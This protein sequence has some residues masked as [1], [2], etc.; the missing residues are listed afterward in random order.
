MKTSRLS[1]MLGLAAAGVLSLATL[2][3]SPAQT[4]RADTLNDFAIVV[5]L[6][7]LNTFVDSANDPITIDSDTTTGTERTITGTE[8]SGVPVV[9]HV[10]LN[11]PTSG[12]STSAELLANVAAAAGADDPTDP[13]TP[14]TTAPDVSTFVP[15]VVTATTPTTITVVWRAPSLSTAFGLTIDGAV[16]PTQAT[17]NFTITGLQ[18]DTAHDLDLE[19][20]HAGPT[21][22]TTA[23]PTPPVSALCPSP[24]GVATTDL[25][26]WNLSE[27][28]SMGL[29]YIV[30]GG[31]E[32]L[33]GDASANGKA[34]GYYPSTFDLS[35]AGDPA[36][37]WTGSTTRPGLQLVTDFNNDGTPDGILV[38]ETAYGSDWWASNG[39]AQFV[40]DNAPQHG[41]GS[42]SVNH[43]TLP[44]W[45]TAFPDAKVLAVGY[46]LGSGAKGNGRINSIVAGCTEYTFQSA[47]L[48]AAPTTV[49]DASSY[50]SIHTPEPLLSGQSERAHAK[51]MKQV[52]TE[53]TDVSDVRSTEF[54]YRT[55]IPYYTTDD[56]PFP[57]DQLFAKACELYN[58][59]NP[60]GPY[61][62][63]G[64]NRSF[65]QPDADPSVHDYRTM[66]DWKVDWDH[67]DSSH[68]KQVGE[69]KLLDTS[70]GEVLKSGHADTARM[71]FDSPVQ[72]SDFAAV[73]FNH[74]AHD[75]LCPSL[76]TAGTVAYD[77]DV[78]FYRSGMVTV[79]GQRFT[80]PAHEGW[81]RW[82]GEA[83]W[84][85]VFEAKTAS[86]ACL[87]G[88]ALPVLFNPCVENIASRVNRTTDSW[89]SFDG[90]WGTTAAGKI[91]GTGNTSRL[92]PHGD[93]SSTCYASGIVRAP[94][95]PNGARVTRL[96]IT[97]LAL[98]NRT[99]QWAT[100]LGSDG[101]IYTWG[102][103]QA[104]EL[105]RTPSASDEIIPT[106]VDSRTYVDFSVNGQNTFAVT[107]DG[108]VYTW[109]SQFPDPHTS[110]SPAPI[111]TPTLSLA[112]ENIQHV[113][114]G[115][116]DAVALNA[117]GH[118]YQFGQSAPSDD[119]P[120]GYQPWHSVP[121]AGKTFSDIA[122][123]GGEIDDDYALDTGG[124]LWA[125]NG[126]T[127]VTAATGSYSG[128]RPTAPSLV[129]TDNTFEVLTGGN[130]VVVQTSDGN[131]G[132]WNEF[133]GPGL[134]IDNY[135]Y[136][137]E[138]P[139]VTLHA[140]T[141]NT[142]T[143]VSRGIGIDGS[144][145]AWAMELKPDYSGYVWVNLGPPPSHDQALA[146]QCNP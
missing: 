36:L 138:P 3:L 71:T 114:V 139:P 101:H 88:G 128:T 141:T 80:A 75:P 23:A 82:N 118:L 69:T 87:A 95:L 2:G 53:A 46:S 67:N 12:E 83:N 109:G 126:N 65:Q 90:S 70:T 110:T 52:A 107:D 97:D 21:I 59:Y 142:A 49:T 129:D 48:P 115:S 55:F 54:Q 103:G 42:G 27:S 20:L 84:T 19:S 74:V 25:S 104:K 119:N 22:G 10:Y 8:S 11:D 77:V 127:V 78:S 1:I 24:R 111:V 32:V 5:N 17:P 56:S 112:S 146:T 143:G 96:Q 15:Q 133:M 14:A 6:A 121:V 63:A 123:N 72:N 18:A 100:A 13:G 7:Q 60:A 29:S 89:K 122:A 98:P 41:S 64:D 31:L 51:A 91:W 30:P 140:L 85:N 136:P 76:G 125:W 86:L 37:D 132:N 106:A 68:D 117:S 79:Y 113:A 145:D 39:S 4:A 131:V 94:S 66:M 137:Q 50:L 43:G 35:I 134:H 105:G 124:H 130:N 102:N 28:G 38:G 61:T 58:G 40:K 57:A 33:T 116:Y 81:V 120:Y 9:I 47:D 16:L 144:G 73:K 135:L 44:E 108:D 93:G 99:D 45:T 34:A 92:A 62:F 26:T